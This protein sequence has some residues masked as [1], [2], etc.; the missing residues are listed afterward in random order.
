[1]NA[2]NYAQNPSI[3]RRARDFYATYCAS[4]DGKNYQGNPCP[5]WD[6]LTEAVRGHWYTVALRSLQLEV[7]AGDEPRRAPVAGDE[8]RHAPNGYVLDQLGDAPRALDV[9]RTYSGIV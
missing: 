5:A 2:V 8:T 3:L 6:A 4:S 9:W 7:A 1:V